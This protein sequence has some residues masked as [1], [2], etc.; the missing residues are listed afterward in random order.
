MHSVLPNLS[1]SIKDRID[2]LS[3]N[4]SGLPKSGD[5]CGL[6]LRLRDPHD[7]LVR[8]SDLFLSSSAAENRPQGFLRRFSRG[9]HPQEIRI[10]GSFPG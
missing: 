10:R 7:C 8:P 2:S 9:I 3:E 6:T 4:R 5:L 1:S